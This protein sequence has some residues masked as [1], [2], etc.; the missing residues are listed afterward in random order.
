MIELI[1]D[2]SMLDGVPGFE[3]EVR[4]YILARAEK[5]C[6]QVSVDSQGN[7]FAFKKGNRTP[8]RPIMLTAHMDEVGFLVN[9][10]TEDGMLK[11]LASG[12]IDPRVLIGR[13]MKVGK[14]KLP[15]VISLK[16]KHLTKPD[17][18]KKA[19]ELKSL[20]IDI[21][22]SG[23]EDALKY[24]SIG[25]MAVFDSE[26]AL[27]G[28]DCI[29][30]KALDDRIGCAILLK[31]MEQ[32]LGYDTWFVFTAA[33]EIGARGAIN[34]VQHIDPGF[35][36]AV[37]STGAGDTADTPEHLRSCAMR[38]GAVISLIDRGT[39]FNRALREKVTAEL[40]RQ[41]IKWQYRTR[42]EG[43][44]DAM[45][46]IYGTGAKVFG[47]STPVRYIHCANSVA[48]LPDIEA[49]LKAAGVFIEEA[50]DMNA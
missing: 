7:L 10:I 20:Y 23:R 5:L 8:A 22:A 39:V 19:P 29:K 42:S 37:D 24:V 43:A 45:A 30:G 36:A 27:F 32:E 25:D 31:L 38:H 47:L 2:L 44:T 50:G 11:I 28:N 18:R 3:G 49:V 9:S 21:G 4:N 48:Y 17:E 26:F 41:C 1:R 12:S 40:D 35:I 46:H 6:D 13:K 15:G 14:S 33:E 34:A 16:A